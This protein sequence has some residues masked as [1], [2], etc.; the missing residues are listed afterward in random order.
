VQGIAALEML[1]CHGDVPL[2][3]KDLGFGSTKALHA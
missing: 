2:G 1:K 3:Q